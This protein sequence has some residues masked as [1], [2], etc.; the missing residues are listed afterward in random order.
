MNIRKHLDAFM[1]KLGYVRAPALSEPT[2]CKVKIE[3]DS[4]EV[5]EALR[6][7]EQ[8]QADV[9]S[10][11]TKHSEARLAASRLPIVGAKQPVSSDC[12]RPSRTQGHSSPAE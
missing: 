1:A 6:L 8:A 11:L 4:S 5:R 7:I 2:I 12:V 10:A 3:V 9:T